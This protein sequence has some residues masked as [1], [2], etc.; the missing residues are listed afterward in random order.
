MCLVDG[1]S[2]FIL[3]TLQITPGLQQGPSDKQ[4]NFDVIGLN[5]K[6]WIMMM[7]LLWRVIYGP[8]PASALPLAL[9]SACPS[10]QYL[11]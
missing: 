9:C 11:P 6:N 4:T 10:V 3:K 7:I 1:Y 8:F 2:L 5:I